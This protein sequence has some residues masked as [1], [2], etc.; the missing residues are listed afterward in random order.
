MS[1]EPRND[2]LHELQK[3]FHPSDVYWK[4]G[5]LNKDQTK[6]LAMAYAT[7]RAYQNR[8]DEICGVD[9]AV[10]YLPWGE[11][12]ICNLTIGGVTRSSTGEADSREEKSEIAGTAAEA[13]AFKRACS[14]FG[15]GRYL[16]FLPTAWVEYDAQTRQF[17][18]Q[19]KARLAGI[20]MQH[21][22]RTMDPQAEV[23]EPAL[24]E[25][26]AAAEQVEREEEHTDAPDPALAKL[27]TQLH[28]LGRELYGE[29]WNQVRHHNVERITQG[30][31]SSAN[32]LTAEQLQ[33]LIAGMKQLK[34]KGSAKKGE[35][36]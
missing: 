8:L 26:A 19:A 5:S 3:P 15:L 32:D 23:E 9:W 6:A 21:Y 10:S 31:S 20:V 25:S 7:L 34:R 28:Q 4:P 1:T 24:T 2:L 30:Q 14:A 29:N 18:E 35:V 22:R 27:R 17:T 33:K 11:R 16:Y 36:A 13:Q 12:I